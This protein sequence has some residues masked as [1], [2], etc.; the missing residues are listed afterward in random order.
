MCS[1]QF[2][3]YTHT[4]SHFFKPGFQMKLKFKMCSRKPLKWRSKGTLLILRPV[5]LICAGS[6]ALIFVR[7]WMN[8]NKWPPNLKY[9]PLFS[10]TRSK[11]SHFEPNGVGTRCLHRTLST[12]CSDWDVRSISPK[13]QYRNVCSSEDLGMQAFRS[14]RSFTVVV[15]P[16][17]SEG[18]ANTRRA[19]SQW[20]LLVHEAPSTIVIS[21]ISHS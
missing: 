2:H 7:I 6:F 19:S 13:V 8:S 17:N 16:I 10:K 20:C 12:K 21:I 1:L 11:H 3:A 5:A 9:A 15:S 18:S 14:P 4:S